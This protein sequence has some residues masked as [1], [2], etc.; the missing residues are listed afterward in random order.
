M[1]AT[2]TSVCT[3]VIHFS[4]VQKTPHKIVLTPPFHKNKKK[5]TG[6]GV[7]TTIYLRPLVTPKLTNPYPRKRSEV[8]S[9]STSWYIHTHI[10]T[11]T[12]YHM[13]WNE[14]TSLTQKRRRR[15][16]WE[17]GRPPRRSPASALC[18]ETARGTRHPQSPPTPSL[19]S[20]AGPPPPGCWGGTGI[21][22]RRSFDWIGGKGREGK[23]HFMA[24]VSGEYD[25]KWCG[26]EM[27]RYYGI[28]SY[29]IWDATYVC[30][31]IM[32]EAQ[33]NWFAIVI[34]M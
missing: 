27:I 23:G 1:A 5:M 15:C 24:P 4:P 19:A 14:I 10:H 6:F 26:V 2:A 7:V 21:R 13:V 28:R 12:W 8:L 18:G 25:M 11:Y 34:V 3:I 20:W 22:T 9:V 16:R 29:T 30:S 33:R 32:Y 31:T 17:S